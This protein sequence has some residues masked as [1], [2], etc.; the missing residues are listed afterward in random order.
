MHYPEGSNWF[1]I[2]TKS[3]Q[4][5]L[6]AYYLTSHLSLDV[7]NPK[8]EKERRVFGR[9]TATRAPLFPCYL[10]ARFD[11]ARSLHTIQ[12]TRGVRKVLHFGETLLRVEDDVVNNIRE[13]M[14]S[15]DCVTLIGPEL[16]DGHPVRITK[17]AFAG[18][19]G[20][21]QRRM[22]DR[23][24]VVLLLEMLGS[25]A[26]VVIDDRFLAPAA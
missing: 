20:I 9:I 6:V 19:K 8:R 11:P 2:Q 21:L 10:F 1:A 24:R 3:G 22:N 13:R 26:A 12:Y 17:G 15:N 25:S 4:E 23:K 14:N 18:L 7:L 16:K 5:D